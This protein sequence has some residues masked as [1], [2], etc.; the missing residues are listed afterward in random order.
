[1][2]DDY[3]FEGDVEGMTKIALI[4]F[5]VLILESI[6]R[7]F[8]IYSTSWL[9]QSVVR[10]LRKRVFDHI[11]DLRLRYFD[12]TPIG[13]STTRTINDIETINTVFTKVLLPL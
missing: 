6:I 9:G 7:Y 10:D 4:I 13:T 11:T 3:I 5:G 1:M 8:F 2:V 12:V